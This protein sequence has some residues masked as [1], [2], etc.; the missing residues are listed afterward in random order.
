MANKK[1]NAKVAFVGDSFQAIG[2]ETYSPVMQSGNYQPLIPA[3]AESQSPTPPI[4][5]SGVQ[6]G[7]NNGSGGAAPS[8]KNSSSD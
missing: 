1:D 8:A 6:P 5:V 4:G 3:S 2:E 7:K